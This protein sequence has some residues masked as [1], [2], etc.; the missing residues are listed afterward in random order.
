[1]EDLIHRMV[2]IQNDWVPP[3]LLNP[4]LIS[5]RRG[6]NENFRFPYKG[7]KKI[8]L[9]TLKRRRKQKDRK[10]ARKICRRHKK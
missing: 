4:P 3:Y 5:I 1:M 8:S 9:K 7:K 2:S 6:Y 10:L